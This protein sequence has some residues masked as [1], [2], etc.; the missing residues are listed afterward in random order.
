MA[1][2]NRC[3]VKE[4]SKQVVKARARPGHGDRRAAFEDVVV[5]ASRA[6]GRRMAQLEIVLL[7]GFQARLPSGL[8]LPVPGH[9]AQALLAYLAL[10][11]GRAHP[12]DKLAALL[13]PDVPHERARQSLRQALTTL[14]QALPR[15]ALTDDGDAIALD[16]VVA[17]IDAA[18]FTSAVAEDNPEALE[19]AVAL[20]RGDLLA[21]LATQAAPFEEWLLTEREALREQAVEALTKLLACQTRSGSI[22]QAIQ[23]A[24]RSLGLD[25]TQEPVHRTLMQLYARQGRRGAALRH[26]QVCVAALER[27]LGIE[28]D[29]GTKALYQQLL[30]SDPAVSPARDR[31]SEDNAPRHRGL[32]RFERKALTS[33]IPLVGREEEVARLRQARAAAWQKHG[34]TALIQ[35]EAGIGKTRLAEAL[36]ADALEAG[37]QV[38]FGRAYETQ[39]ILPFGPWVEA[40]RA[41]E[42]IAEVASREEFEPSVR[43]DLARLFPE[44]GSPPRKLGSV[45]YVRL[46]DA[47]ARVIQE[48]AV[49]QPLLLVLEDLH[50]ADEMSL[51]LL[52]FVTRRL[53]GSRTLILGSARTEE[54][55]ANPVLGRCV[56]ELARESGFSST[57]LK[58]LSEYEIAALVRTLARTGLDELALSRLAGE[59]WRVSEGNPFM[60]VETVR[61]LPAPDE[62]KAAPPSMPARIREMISS[63]LARLTD[64]GRQLAQAASVIGRE[65]DFALL[66]R[67]VGYTPQ[68]A[69]EGVED[70]VARRILQVVGERL[71]FTHDRIREVVYGGLLAPRRKLLHAGVAKSIEALYDRELEPHYLA[72]GL[73]Y[74]NGDAWDRAFTYLGEAGRSAAARSAHRDAVTSF[75]L[76]LDCA[77]HLPGTPEV[78]REAIDLRF[79]LRNALLLLGEPERLASYLHEAETMARALDDRAR[80]A[81]ASAY[82]SHYLW[83][84]GRSRDAVAHARDALAAADECGDFA[85]QV[86]A[87]L[88]LGLASHTAG[89]YE[90]TDTFLGRVIDQLQGPRARERLGQHAYPAVNARSH[91]IYA[92]A[93]RGDF[94]RSM[95]EGDEALRLAEE[96]D[97]PLSLVY[98]CWGLAGVHRARGEFVEAARLLERALVVAG[99]WDITDWRPIVTALLG[100]AYAHSGRV[101]EGL[102]LLN[103]GLNAMGSAGLEVFRSLILVNLGEASLHAGRLTEAATC[104]SQALALTCDRGE[105]GFEAAA[106]RLIADVAAQTDSPDSCAAEDQYRRALELAQ[107][108]GM[109]PLVAQCR[110]GLGQLWAKVGRPDRSRPEFEVARELFGELGMAS[111]LK[112]AHDV[113]AS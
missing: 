31:E 77:R 101:P 92:L 111:W 81:R 108:L 51:R 19:R 85:L 30:Q 58:P 42:V 89:E 62:H 29:A 13:W 47:M 63:R 79:D 5:L 82:S 107:T 95:S 25:A 69:A 4:V 90:Q 45:D 46:F 21:G 20:Y 41:G 7:G 22:E 64:H 8:P 72:L 113:P 50:W 2:C 88:I 39:Q 12:R 17:E 87:N 37:G 94:D 66:V 1:R 23:T 98:A 27:E 100:D 6:S 38:L 109:R 104:A 61:E 70:L 80:L 33:G 36:I 57:T 110:L 102:A 86:A 99:R 93:E 26:Y 75:E 52:A 78:V 67:A 76:A 65:F 43:T 97:H 83:R 54:M 48:L 14:R 15:E 68:V 96:L 71:D 16:P 112:R 53:S 56:D 32:V 60:A 10:P 103:E 28:P 35:G 44:L 34:A 59:I 73:H 24:V 11:P 49:R 105:R 55:V 9:K 18:G 91:L 74:R 106:R 40:F 84:T 3:H